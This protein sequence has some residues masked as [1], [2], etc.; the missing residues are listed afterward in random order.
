[1]GLLAVAACG[2]IPEPEGFV[3]PTSTTS[4]VGG[5][6]GEAVPDAGDTAGVESRSR[7]AFVPS[8][9]DNYVAD[10][11]LVVNGEVL[12]A[13]DGTDL[14]SVPSAATVDGVVDAADDFLRG[15]VVER[16][17]AEREIVWLQQGGSADTVE[18][19]S[20]DLLDVGY[21]EGSPVA[22]V[23]TGGEV[24]ELIRLV[25]SE[26]TTMVN[27]RDDEQLLSL[28]ASG[29]LYALVVSNEQCGDLRFYTGDGTEVQLGGPGEPDCIV[30]RRPAYGA[31]A[32][33]PS[34]QDMAY[35]VV[36]YRADGI[37]ESTELVLRDLTT[38]TDYRRRVIGDLGDRVE[39]LSFDGDRV[40]FARRSV[41]GGE[42]ALV[43]IGA[44]NPESIIETGSEAQADSVSFA[45]LPLAGDS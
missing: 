41:D 32:L 19:G 2:E 9:P 39:S 35:T 13:A 27:L 20:V 24:V 25:D 12:T 4:V 15:L 11:L 30:P 38:E 14:V 21:Q 22:V 16:A 29:D 8:P 33:S 26:R 5:L 31:V 40:V 17:A 6:V 18:S 36:T 28:S 3:A 23:L 10:L 44:E 37:P 42:V 45:R 34:G 1:L 43:E 7:P